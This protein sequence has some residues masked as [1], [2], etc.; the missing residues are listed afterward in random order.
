MNPETLTPTNARFGLTHPLPSGPTEP[1]DRRGLA[2]AGAAARP[3][4]GGVAVLHDLPKLAPG[5]IAP[6]PQDRPVAAPPERAPDPRT[7]WAR[8]KG[9]GSVPAIDPEPPAP[10]PRLPV[11]GPG[12]PRPGAA[13]LPGQR[14]GGGERAGPGR[15]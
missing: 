8:A 2:R 10:P 9:L 1:E 15:G 5:P 14:R 7:G 6:D 12:R 11:L 3:V 13:G 4:P